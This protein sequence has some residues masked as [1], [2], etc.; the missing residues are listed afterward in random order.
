MDPEIL[1][2]MKQEK[3]PRVHQ[4]YHQY[5]W[6]P[7]PHLFGMTVREVPVFSDLGS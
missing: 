6:I 4:T 5:E 1:G 2:P 7:C 3:T